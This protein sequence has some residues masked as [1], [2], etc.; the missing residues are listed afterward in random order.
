MTRENLCKSIIPSQRRLFDIPDEIAYFNCAYNSPQLNESLNRLLLG[1]HAKSHPWERTPAS[2]FDDAE[3]IRRLSSN[4][5]G[6]DADG[7]AVIP[8]ASYGLS[9]AARAIVHMDSV[10]CMCLNSGA[11]PDHSKKHGLLAVTL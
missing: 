10:C 9:S 1:A 3:A 11:V 8:A 2:F 7:Y 6:G 4:I 5:F